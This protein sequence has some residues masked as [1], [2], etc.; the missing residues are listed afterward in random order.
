MGACLTA[1]LDV[2][3][4]RLLISIPLSEV[5]LILKVKKKFS[6]NMF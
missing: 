6:L 3:F 1:L 5:S 2:I 4:T